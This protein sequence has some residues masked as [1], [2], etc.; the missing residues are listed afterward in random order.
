[1]WN[2]CREEGRETPQRGQC[3][4]CFGLRDSPLMLPTNVE[5]CFT[6]SFQ[7]VAVILQLIS[8]FAS[9]YVVHC[10]DH[11]NSNCFFDNDHVIVIIRINDHVI[12]DRKRW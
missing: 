8:F 5:N 7:L 3:C 10:F 2:V 4:A 12:R 9:S 6:D 11:S 1:M